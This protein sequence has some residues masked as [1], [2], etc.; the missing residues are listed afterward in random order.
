MPLRSPA[1]TWLLLAATV[2]VY[3]A[4][5]KWMASLPFPTPPFAWAVFDALTMA[6]VGLVCIW[7]SLRLEKPAWSR[8]APVTA[9]LL[10]AAL[11]AGAINGAVTYWEKFWV[12]LPSYGVYAA[13]LLAAL[14]I[15]QRAGFWR[16]RYGTIREWQF[17]L[18]ELLATMTAAAVLIGAIRQSPFL[19]Y[20]GWQ[21][22][23]LVASSVTLAVACLI[24]W[25][26]TAHWVLRLAGCLGMAAILGVAT[27]LA[28]GSMQIYAQIF[29]ADLLIQA[30]V[31]SAWL[32]WGRITPRA[33]AGVD[34]ALSQ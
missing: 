22:I 33:D 30:L 19:E 32:G 5:C 10:A 4:M 34:R 1:I 3:A 13:L 20:G 28:G 23:A 6:Q 15:V 27:A 11:V 2:S 21:T 9:A 25:G 14:W 26:G 17:S 8:I 24:M 7:S 29:A 12:L 16:R 31:L 18:A